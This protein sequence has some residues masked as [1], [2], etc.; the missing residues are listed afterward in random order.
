MFYFALILILCGLF[1]LLFSLLLSS[2]RESS[3]DGYSN[4]E[5]PEIREEDLDLDIDFTEKV[6]ADSDFDLSDNIVERREQPLLSSDFDDEADDIFQ[7]DQDIV[8]HRT[9]KEMLFTAVLFEDS[10]GTVDYSSGYGTIDPTRNSY[11]NI[12]RRGSGEISLE[13]AGITF[14]VGRKLFRYDFHKFRSFFRGDNYVA[15]IPYGDSPVKLFIFPQP[16]PIIHLI[17]ET[18]NTYKQ[19]SGR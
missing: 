4:S 18:F 16:G 2:A 1:L 11:R 5:F 3:S 13:K 6:P 19:S 8:D 15:L 7:G 10:S 12:K 14:H 9:E 17:S